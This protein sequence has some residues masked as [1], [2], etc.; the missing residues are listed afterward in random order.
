ML[1]GLLFALALVS[2]TF[3]HAPRTVG[4]QIHLK[5]E[6]VD[7]GYSDAVHFHHVVHFRMSM[8]F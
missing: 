8:Y 2:W 7:V 5:H 4:L 6:P 3:S 1:V